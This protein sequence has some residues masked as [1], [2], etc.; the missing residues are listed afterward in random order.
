VFTL[1]AKVEFHT[2]TV[3]TLSKDT[4]L[5]EFLCRVNTEVPALLSVV[6]SC[7]NKLIGTTAIPV[8]GKQQGKMKM[9]FPQP[10]SGELILISISVSFLTGK[11]MIKPV[12]FEYDGKTVRH[13]V[14]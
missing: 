6:M 2:P 12:F 3:K 11:K 1:P 9:L 7:Q 10:A 4:A 8:E 14:R 5:L 13:V